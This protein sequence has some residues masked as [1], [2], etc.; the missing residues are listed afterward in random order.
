MYKF[1]S[2]ILYR[3]NNK[4]ATIN[5]FVWFY[6]PKMSVK[7]FGWA[8]VERFGANIIS[9]IGNIA[10]SYLVAP[11]DFGV[12]GVL[13]IFSMLIYVFTDC[14]LSDGIM[15]KN[16]A[17]PADF[18]TMFWFNVSVGLAIC[19]IYNIL[20]RPI[21]I[22]MGVPETEDVMRALGVGAI[23]SSMNIARLTKLRYDLKFKKLSILNVMSTLSAVITALILAYMGFS[24][25]A[26]VALT[27]GYVVYM[28][29]FLSLFMEFRVKF[30]FCVQT[31]RELW[32]FGVNLLFST[33]VIQVAQN[34]YTFLL[35]RSSAV[36]EAGYMNQ[37]QK[38]EDA[39]LRSLESV[40]SVTSYALVA[41]IGDKSCRNAEILN[42]YGMSLFLFFFFSGCLYALGYHVVDVVFAE[43]WLPIVPYFEVLLV[44]GA[45][46]STTRFLQMILKLYGRTDLVRNLVLFEN[47]AVIVSAISLFEVGLLLALWAYAV[48]MILMSAVY[49]WYCSAIADIRRLQLILPLLRSVLIAV[50]SALLTQLCVVQMGNSF[51]ALISGAFL[52]L[53]IHLGFSLILCRE[54]AK[55]YRQIF[56]RVMREIKK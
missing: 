42:M 50:A 51:V 2:V 55:I 24:Y 49:I 18:N 6:N 11:S 41:K 44:V 35:G 32:A 52:F 8:A 15:R 3:K 31:F 13:A 30:E 48:I 45:F 17:S 39:P 54:N 37:A 5:Q 1:Y 27:V 7:Y 4:I 14:G 12:V 20:A 19:L 28:Q 40:M 9:L 22:Y 47:V 25:W 43:K 21:S 36:A 34:I 16:N 33:I 23:F 26:V 46:R 56:M 38:M 10:L 29:L 53:S